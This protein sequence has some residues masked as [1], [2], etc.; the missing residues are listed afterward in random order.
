MEVLPVDGMLTSEPVFCWSTGFEIFKLAG[1]LATQV[2]RERSGDSCPEG[3]PTGGP[4]RLH[5]HVSA[6]TDPRKVGLSSACCIHIC[7]RHVQ[8]IAESGEKCV[9]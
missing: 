7:D 2:I 8:L 3:L 9:S 6:V 1:S 4:K 5:T